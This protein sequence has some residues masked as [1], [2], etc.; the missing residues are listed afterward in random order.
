MFRHD[1]VAPAS[2]KRVRG[3]HE[4]RVCDGDVPLIIAHRR[5]S[6]VSIDAAIRNGA[7]GVEVDVR[8]HG[9]ELVL[10]HDPITRTRRDLLRLEELDAFS[11][12][13]CAIYLDF[14]ED[15]V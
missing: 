7:D 1:N 8:W 13:S 3:R 14:K 11:P 2:R 4:S 15:A 10:A 6:R 12:P 9:R 5:N